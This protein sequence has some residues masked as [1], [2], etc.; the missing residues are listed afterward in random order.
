MTALLVS[1]VCADR[2]PHFT[3]DSRRYSSAFLG[4]RATPSLKLCSGGLSNTWANNACSLAGLSLSLFPM[5]VYVGPGSTSLGEDAGLRLQTS[6]CSST[7]C[8]QKQALQSLQKRPFCL[9]Y[10]PGTS[11]HHPAGQ[12]ASPSRPLPP[13]RRLSNL[14]TQ[15]RGWVSSPATLIG[16]RGV[17]PT[18]CFSNQCQDDTDAAGAGTALESHCCG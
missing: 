16:G 3:R 12:T 14:N 8:R 18:T 13:D 5:Q 6:L 10:V 9:P 4:T 1:V 2:P 17:A 11:M 15:G 7:A